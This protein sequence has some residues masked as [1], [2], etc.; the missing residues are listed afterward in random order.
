[1]TNNKI[2]SDEEKRNF[3]IKMKEIIK[4]CRANKIYM[5]ANY[6]SYSFWL[7]DK[8][9]LVT[10]YNFDDYKKYLKKL[11]NQGFYPAAMYLK[12]L[13]NEYDDNVIRIQASKLRIMEIYNDLKAG[14]QLDKNGREIMKTSEI[15][16]KMDDIYYITQYSEFY[17]DKNV[18]E[19]FNYN[20][21]S[22]KTLEEQI[23]YKNKIIEIIGKMGYVEDKINEKIYHR[24]V[25]SNETN[26]NNLEQYNLLLK[27]FSSDDW[28]NQ[29]DN[30][31]KY[32]FTDF[33]NDNNY[34]DKDMA[35]EIVDGDLKENGIDSQYIYSFNNFNEITDPLYANDPYVY[36][37]PYLRVHNVT[38]DKIKNEY[39]DFVC[40]NNN[41][42]TLEEKQ[43]YKAKITEQIKNM[44]DDWINE[45]EKQLKH[46]VTDFMWENNY[47]LR[48]QLIEDIDNDLK[49]RG[50]DSKW[51]CASSNSNALYD[52]RKY[53][54]IDPYLHF[55]SVSE[56]ELKEAYIDSISEMK[57]EDVLNL[58][59]PKMENKSSNTK[60][61][62]S[63]FDKTPT[64]FEDSEVIKEYK[65]NF[66]EKSNNN[67]NIKSNSVKR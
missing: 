38:E 18:L 53:V 13:E 20:L 46:S 63:E 58:D 43:E 10:N 55:H 35:W 51:I 6:N 40:D 29:S 7:N 33:A 12:M 64:P 57:L 16:F 14:K 5:A 22:L 31:L 48:E 44:G 24:L 62:L 28:I 32:G 23:Q 60:N 3:A 42:E 47:I 19:A 39:I 1:M 26:L 4:F 21:K 37:D 65:K 56:S 8:R 34:L 50:E 9:Y 27:T 52:D 11:S 45:C 66:N 49:K 2:F 59:V 67:E 54:Y 41:F 36:V 15:E 61:I 25:S 17:Y 30:T